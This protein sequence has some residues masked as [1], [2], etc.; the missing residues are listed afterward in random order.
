MRIHHVA[1]QVLLLLV[2]GSCLSVVAAE[3]SVEIPFKLHDGFAIVVR[4]SV[5]RQANLNFL[6]DTGAVPSAIHQRVAGLNLTDPNQNISVVNQ[7]RSVQR[8]ELPNLHLGPVELPALSAVVVDLSPIE[9][10]LELRVDAIVGVTPHTQ[11]STL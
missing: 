2:S 4:G 3:P 6:V 10:R 1:L 7:S 8:A 5:G 9:A 11:F